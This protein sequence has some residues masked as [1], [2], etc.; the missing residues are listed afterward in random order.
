MLEMI[1]CIM[2]QKQILCCDVGGTN[3]SIALVRVEGD[4]YH[5][6]DIQR[7]NTQSLENLEQA[8]DIVIGNLDSAGLS[9]ACSGAGHIIN[10]VSHLSNVSWK[11][12][13]QKIANHYKI[14]TLLI[15]DFS[16][17]AYS[18]PIIKNNEQ[19]VSQ[20]QTGEYASDNTPLYVVIGSG[21]G[22]G[23]GAL[24]HTKDSYVAIPSEGGHADVIPMDEQTEALFS[25]WRKKLGSPPGAEFFVSGP[26]IHNISEYFIDS[27]SWDSQTMLETIR[28]T[29]KNDRSKLITTHMDSD[30]QCKNI[31]DIFLKLLARFTATTCM[32]FGLHVHAFLAGGIIAKHAQTIKSSS[33]FQDAFCENY[34]ELF[35]TFLKKIPISIIT[36]YNVSLIG[37]AHAYMHM[38]ASVL[39]DIPKK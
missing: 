36:D 19:T 22:L 16:A 13:A 4:N 34:T 23:T 29:D 27:E 26:G 7:F 18:L 12:D 30:P 33:V 3:T 11:I 31:W 14:P 32:F 38:G 24:M 39:P 28:N 35:R 5:I 6:G 20:L 2:Q 10:H 8:L 25:Y 17:L 37:V 1:L 15:N 21:T 9:L